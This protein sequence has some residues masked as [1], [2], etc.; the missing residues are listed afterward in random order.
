MKTGLTLPVVGQTVFGATGYQPP[1]GEVVSVN[2][3]D[4]HFTWR[5]RNRPTGE[6]D[7][8]MPIITNVGGENIVVGRHVGSRTEVPN[9]QEAYA[10][11]FANDCRVTGLCGMPL[12]HPNFSN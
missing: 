8:G 4:G 6:G 12:A 7:S 9:M 5:P 11:I 10:T 2:A 3:E 1:M